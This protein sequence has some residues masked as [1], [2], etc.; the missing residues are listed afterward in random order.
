MAKRNIYIFLVI[1]ICMTRS[2]ILNQDVTRK[3]YTASFIVKEFSQLLTI[4]PAD[5]TVEVN[6]SRYN[7]QK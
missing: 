4:I 5:I 3:C 2:P 7:S 6:I 1:Y